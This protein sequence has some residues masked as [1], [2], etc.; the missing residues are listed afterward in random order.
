LGVLLV[1]LVPCTDWFITFSQLGRADL[2]RAMAVTPIN[3]I[4]QLLLLPVYLWI[5]MGDWPEVVL[6]E[7]FGVGQLWPALLVILLPLLAACLAEL[8]MQRRGSR[9]ILRERLAW[10]PVPLL[11]WVIMMVAAIQVQQVFGV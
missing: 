2:P 11:A 9:V 10:W 1:L 3:L 5:F 7:V 6:G 4:L 8:W